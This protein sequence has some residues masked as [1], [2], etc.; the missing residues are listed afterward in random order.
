M[1]KTI[2]IGAV[3]L[4]LL[5]IL[6]GCAK[7]GP[8]PAPAPPATPSTPAAKTPSPTPASPSISP[9]ATPSTPVAK[10]PIPTPTPVAPSVPVKKIEVKYAKGF[11]VEYLPDGCKKVTDA[12]GQE[13]ILIP[14][15]KRVSGYEEYMR[16]EIPVRRVVALS[17]TEVCLLRPLEVLDSI[18]GVTTKK[19]RW[20]IKEIKEGMEEG[21]IELVGGGMGEPDYE[22]I[23][24]LKPDVVF[25]YTGYPAAVK[26]F[27]KLKEM[28]IPVA[29]DNEWLEN[30][31]LGRLEWMKFLAAFYDKDAQAEEFFEKVEQR[32]R[33]IAFEVSMEK[34]PNVLWGLTYKG[35]CY[36][37]AGDSYVAKMISLAG[38]NY[39]FSDLEGTGSA[40]VTL[41][42]FYARGKNADIFIYSSRPPYVK[43][44]KD[45]VERGPALADIKPVKEGKVWCFQPWYWQSID[46]TDGIIEDL[47][48]IFHPELYPEHELGYFM[49]L[50]KVEKP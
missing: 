17:T 44:I 4:S 22:R 27:E 7:A 10:T 30:D 28:G 47:A 24:A 33:E 20:Y 16:M 46:K 29:V 18:I 23:L 31:P 48:A 5:L 13:F 35:K 40:N 21:R 1:R 6:V 3:I 50:P 38:G 15:G 39:L 42:E 37:P 12:E 32:A 19:E 11:K 9:P 2:L 41:E 8:S 34:R 25:M 14:R 26:S 43:S 36:V 49:K 45:I